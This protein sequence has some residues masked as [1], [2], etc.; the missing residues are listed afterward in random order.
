MFGAFRLQIA[1]D[2]FLNSVSSIIW[3]SLRSALKSL[4]RFIQTLKASQSPS[5]S[6][7]NFVELTEPGVS[8]L[9]PSVSPVA[10]LRQTYCDRSGSRDLRPSTRRFWSLIAFPVAFRNWDLEQEHLGTF[11]KY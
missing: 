10:E 4:A 1:S 3:D 11:W 6:S 9:A 8:Q 7:F 5:Q 2:A